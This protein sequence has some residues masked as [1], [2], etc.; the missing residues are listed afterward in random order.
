MSR[1]TYASI[2]KDGHPSLRQVSSPITL[3]PSKTDL[4]LAKRLLRYVKDSRNDELAEKYDLKPA[5][6]LSAPQVGINKQLFVVRIDDADGHWQEYVLANPKLVSHSVQK[7]ALASGEG[8]L[9]IEETYPG[10]VHRH[11]RITLKAYDMLKG[12]WVDLRLKDF[13]SI[14]FQHEIDHL[15]GVLFYDHIDSND[16]WATLDNTQIIEL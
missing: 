1:I 6:G 4:A 13:L 11:A 10:I 14:V 9:S 16:P 5:V 15:N 3:P 7:S 8:C 12:S 2:V